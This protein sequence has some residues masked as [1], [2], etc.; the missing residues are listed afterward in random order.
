MKPFLKA[1]LG[2]LLLAVL[3]NLTSAQAFFGVYGGL[4]TAGL[5]L[6]NWKASQDPADKKPTFENF[7]RLTFGVTCEL[8]IGKYMYLQP[9]LAWTTKGG[10]MSVDS[11]YGDDQGGGTI[12][13]QTVNNLDLHY[14]QMPILLKWRMQLTNPQPL[15]PNE[16]TG[17]PLFFEFYLGPVVNFL[18]MS[19]SNYSQTI[20]E[21]NNSGPVS[22]DT[23][24]K[25]VHNGAS[26]S[27]LKKLD[28]GA[29]IGGNIKW[30]LSRKCYI[31]LDARYSLN[32]LDI[33][34]SAIYNQYLDKEGNERFGFTPTLKNT[35][36]LALTLGINTT[37]TKRRYWN[38]PR[39][40]NRRF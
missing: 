12:T 8:P 4:N 17:Q 21:I 19:R 2:A 20:H 33:N 31:Y 15:Y 34:G 30:K 1:A 14:V 9:E 16:G 22:I 37:F 5:T 3:P 6:D 28:I 23:T 13:Y 36:N 40:K 35:G 24:Y 25:T 29:A 26:F 38:H 18:L 7:R 39:M 27:G 10:I 11:G 32:F